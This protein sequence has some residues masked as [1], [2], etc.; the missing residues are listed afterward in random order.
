MKIDP[1]ITPDVSSK[2]PAA[3]HRDRSS[4]PKAGSEAVASG[5]APRRRDRVELSAQGIARAG[6]KLTPA[7]TEDI[8]Q[9]IA[10]G[11]YNSAANAEAVAKKLLSSGDL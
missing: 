1:R 3:P 9:K 5:D 6:S 10:D 7:R 11:H 2:A 8:R 4:I